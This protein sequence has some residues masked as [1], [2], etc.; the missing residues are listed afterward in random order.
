MIVCVCMRVIWHVVRI[1]C[2]P[3]KFNAGPAWYFYA[4][5]CE[6][7]EMLMIMLHV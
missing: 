6:S 3:A 2:F 4:I 1:R 5:Q 7:K